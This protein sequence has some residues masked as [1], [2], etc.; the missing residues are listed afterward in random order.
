MTKQCDWPCKVNCA[1]SV[2]GA[3]K[4]SFDIKKED[5]YFNADECRRSHQFQQAVDVPP[6]TALPLLPAVNSPAPKRFEK[7]LIDKPYPD[8]FVCPSIGLFGSDKYCNVYY[9]CKSFHKTPHASYHC[10]DSNFDPISKSCSDA[11]VC[12]FKP[13]LIYPFVSVEEANLPEEVSCSYK[14]GR[15]TK[16]QPYRCFDKQNSADGIYSKELSRCVSKYAESCHGEYFISK[17][18]YQS[19]PIQYQR[20]P[21]LQVIMQRFNLN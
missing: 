11:R 13:A 17:P 5:Y 20:L 16:P 8:E 4:S 2:Y 6:P 18:K 19:S 15:S 21:D 1:D 9:E 3:L 12:A 10:V 14:I 7:K